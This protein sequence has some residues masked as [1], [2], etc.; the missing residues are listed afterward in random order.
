MRLEAETEPEAQFLQTPPVPYVP[1]GQVSHIDPTA[2]V[3]SGHLSQPY[4]KSF[5]AMDLYPVEQAEQLDIPSF[6]A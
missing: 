6:A 2:F 1:K 5:E 4:W 3:P